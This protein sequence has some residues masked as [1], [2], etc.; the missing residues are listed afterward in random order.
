MPAKKKKE[1]FESNLQ[2]LED[3][4]EAMESGELPLE[5]ALAQFEKGVGLAKVLNK[6]LSEAELKVKT[7]LEKE[8]ELKEAAFSSEVLDEEGED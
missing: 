8:G 5:E 4:V 7:L 2:A 6:Q 3:I 1:T